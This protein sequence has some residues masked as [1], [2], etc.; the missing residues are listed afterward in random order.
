MSD[1]MR[2]QIDRLST[3][4]ANLLAVI[5]RDG[6]HYQAEHGT[7]KAVEE[8]KATVF[9]ERAEL[10]ALR[11]AMQEFHDSYELDGYVDTS[12]LAALQEVKDE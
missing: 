11:K 1:S 3:E 5:H 4:L 7:V 2:I 8:A 9:R 12:K 6:G 10:A